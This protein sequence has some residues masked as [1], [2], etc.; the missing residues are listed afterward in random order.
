MI[1]RSSLSPD[2]GRVGAGAADEGRVVARVGRDGHVA[3]HPEA[4]VGIRA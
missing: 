2:E 3:V 1:E 4:A